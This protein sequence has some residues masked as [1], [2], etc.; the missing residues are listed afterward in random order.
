MSGLDPSARIHLKDSLLAYVKQGNTIF[1]SSHILSDIDEIC[2][3][4]AILHNNEI[5]FTGTPKD[6]KNT[7]DKK[8]LERA[9]LKAI[10]A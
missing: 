9:F 6:F 4:C 3:R 2:D 8:S 5:I 7:Y 10:A 1:F